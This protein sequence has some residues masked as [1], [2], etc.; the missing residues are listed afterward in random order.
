MTKEIDGVTFE[1][2]RRGTKQANDIIN[3]AERWSRDWDEVYKRPSNTKAEIK[4]SWENWI[5]DNCGYVLGYTGNTFGFT[6][7][8]AITFNNEL[9]YIQITKDHNRIVL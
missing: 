2:I 4:I 1:V 7:Y 3:T 9:A 5:D 8:G 6:I